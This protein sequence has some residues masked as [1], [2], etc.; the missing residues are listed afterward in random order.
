VPLAWPTSTHPSRRVH[1]RRA[2]RGRGTLSRH[3]L[4][5]RAVLLAQ[6]ELSTSSRR[7]RW[8]EI[9]FDPWPPRRALARRL[10][11]L[12]WPGRS[13]PGAFPAAAASRRGAPQRLA[14]AGVTNWPVGS[15]CAAARRDAGCRA[16]SP[17]VWSLFGRA[18]LLFPVRFSSRSRRP[19]ATPCWYTSSPSGPP[20][21]LGALARMIAFGALLVAAGFGVAGPARLACR[22]GGVL[23]RPRHRRPSGLRPRLCSRSRANPHVLVVRPHALA[24]A[25]SGVGRFLKSKGDAMILRG[26]SSLSRLGGV[27]VAALALPCCRGRRA[28]ASNLPAPAERPAAAPAADRS[29]AATAQDARTAGKG[30]PQN[31]D[32][33]RHEHES[34]LRALAER[35]QVEQ[36][37]ARQADRE[38]KAADQKQVESAIRWLNLMQAIRRFRICGRRKTWSALQALHAAGSRTRRISSSSRRKSSRRGPSCKA[39]EAKL[40]DYERAFQQQLTKRGTGA[41]RCRRRSPRAGVLR[42]AA[43]NQLQPA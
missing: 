40:R 25:A 16:V 2:R 30:G 18:R 19:S 29:P 37:H 34:A 7:Q 27:A 20:R 41:L 42:V 3:R 10:I 32:K 22:R 28:S 9:A 23:R 14:S 43:P 11:A 6:I 17:M 24:L 15:G 36:Q 1:A 39:A 38:R 13:L 35:L 26:H 21:S 8:G 5:I 12:V 31:V 4:S 33:V